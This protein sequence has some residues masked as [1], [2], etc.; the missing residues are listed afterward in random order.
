VRPAAALDWTSVLKLRATVNE[1]LEEAR[2][3]KKIGKSLEAVVE[4]ATSVG[5]VAEG[6]ISAADL[7]ELFIVSKVKVTAGAEEVR[8]SRAEEHGMKKCVRCWRYYDELGSDAA[9]PELCERCTG[10]VK[11]FGESGG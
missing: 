10:V 3:A 9:H 11:M 7:E 5:P 4:I 6:M 2:K 8:V 1:Q